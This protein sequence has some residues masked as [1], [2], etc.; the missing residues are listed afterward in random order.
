MVAERG[1][2][3]NRHAGEDGDAGSYAVKAVSETKKI[4]DSI[5]PLMD[6]NLVQ[7]TDTSKSTNT[8]I[9]L[10]DPVDDYTTMQPMELESEKPTSTA[11]GVL[12]LGGEDAVDKREDLKAE[13]E[14]LAMLMTEV[15]GD[16]AVKEKFVWDGNAVFK[17]HCSRPETEGTSVVVNATEVQ[18]LIETMEVVKL[19]PRKPIRQRT[20]QEME[21]VPTQVQGK[22]VEP[23]P[24]EVSGS[25][26]GEL[27]DGRKTQERNVEE[28]INVQVS[29]V[30][31]ET[32]KAVKIIPQER[33]NVGR[34]N[35]TIYGD[36]QGDHCI[37]FDKYVG[38]SKDQGAYNS[39]SWKLFPTVDV[40]IRNR[41]S[42]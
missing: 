31:E 10:F 35:A 25:M 22:I 18:H 41:S 38:S 26:V 32:T 40:P 9:G 3:T 37:C 29:Q 15:S 8:Q 24:Q 42:R 13:V 33:D 16:N 36:L 19:I 12:H 39:V 7:R 30:M 28:I 1:R 23:I 34:E 21:A 17:I 20:V 11:K 14:P 27:A 4:Y 2:E 6:E 5:L